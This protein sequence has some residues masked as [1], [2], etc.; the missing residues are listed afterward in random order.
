M[1]QPGQPDT[2][3]EEERPADEEKREVQIGK[4]IEVKANELYAM[5]DEANDDFDLNTRDH[6][7]KKI[8]ALAQELV[9]LHTDKG[10]GMHQIAGRDGKKIK[11]FIPGTEKK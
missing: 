2:V 1:S 6:A 7:I 3:N 4:E 5:F 9:E 11:V 10:D 8:K